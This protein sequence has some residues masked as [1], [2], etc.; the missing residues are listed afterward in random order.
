MEL[1][2]FFKITTDLRWRKMQISLNTMSTFGWWLIGCKWR[3]LIREQLHPIVNTVS[4]A[5]KRTDSPWKRFPL[6]AMVTNCYSRGKQ[7]PR[8]CTLIH[9]VAC[10]YT[11]P[12]M[13]INGGTPYEK[14]SW[15]VFIYLY[16]RSDAKGKETP[17]K[18]PSAPDRPV[19]DMWDIQV[20]VVS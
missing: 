3:E 8:P 15:M 13:F 2:G 10:V 6:T 16:S 17:K 19:W 11:S 1:L 4:S 20:I 5:W 18:H 12:L 9:R 14:L 7:Q